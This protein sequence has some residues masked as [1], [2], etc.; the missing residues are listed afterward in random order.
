MQFVLM[1]DVMLI[2]LVPCLSVVL[3][4]AVRIRVT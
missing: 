3:R 1:L 2:L 4:L